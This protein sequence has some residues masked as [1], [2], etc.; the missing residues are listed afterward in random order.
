MLGRAAQATV[1]ARRR[2][3]HGWRWDRQRG[4]STCVV[5]VPATRPV[6]TPRLEVRLPV[7]ADRQQFVELFGD[8][9]FMVFSAGV[10]DV[11]SAHRR[12][13]E[14]LQRAAELAFAKQPV[15]ER[16]T[17]VI[18][19]YAGVDWFQF[20]ENRRLEFGYRL[21]PGARGKGYA[22]EA[23]RVILALAE[24]VFCGEILAMIDPRNTASQNVARKL[25]FTFWKQAIVDGFLDNLYRLQV[26]AARTTRAAP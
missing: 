13:D 11:S 25:G 20:E 18:I 7:E 5:G 4:S 21:V 9:R 12:F 6:L 24:E 26:G 10:L 22:T 19:G 3:E 1:H 8:D 17:G 2:A 14:M 16:E 15:I 23:S